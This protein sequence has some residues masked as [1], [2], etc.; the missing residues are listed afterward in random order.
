MSRGLSRSRYLTYRHAL[1]FKLG[2][3][4]QGKKKMWVLRVRERYLRS[5][6][7]EIGRRKIWFQCEDRCLWHSFLVL[8]NFAGETDKGQKYVQLYPVRKSL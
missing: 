6:K 7:R 2:V 3:R 1:T 5:W 8:S 4:D